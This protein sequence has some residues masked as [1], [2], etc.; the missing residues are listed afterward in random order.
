MR[1]S[2]LLRLLLTVAVAA[3]ISAIV[4][5]VTA[6]RELSDHAELWWRYAL[7]GA[8]VGIVAV[9]L[10]WRRSA[11]RWWELAAFVVP[12]EVWFGAQALLPG[13]KSLSNLVELIALSAFLVLAVMVRACAGNRLT[14]RHALAIQ[15]GLCVIA[16]LAFFLVPGIPE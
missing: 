15:F 16:A 5:R 2:A 8:V 9:P 6:G 7:P 10:S 3:T 14:A 1:S 11:W 13:R 4:W 12:F